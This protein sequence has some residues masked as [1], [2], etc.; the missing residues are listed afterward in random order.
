MFWERFVELCNGIDKK[1]NSIR[2][3]L[4]ISSSMLT[5][6]KNGAMPGADVLTRI[7]DYFGVSTDYLLGR[8][9]TDVSGS[10][11]AV[12]NNTGEFHNND[13]NVGCN[14]REPSSSLSKQEQEL[15]E[16][17]RNLP[18][19]KQAEIIMIMQDSIQAT[20]EK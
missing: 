18:L 20:G 19:R 2:D 15:I 9:V 3:E 5:K 7:A 1:P 10:N 6:Y 17:F 13:V 12:I 11:S 16:M 4:E 8:T 14:V